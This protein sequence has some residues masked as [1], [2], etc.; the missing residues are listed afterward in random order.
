MSGATLTTT[1]DELGAA[2]VLMSPSLSEPNKNRQ[3]PNQRAQL[4]VADCRASRAP[5][6]PMCAHTDKYYSTTF[7]RTCGEPI[8]ARKERVTGATVC[9]DFFRYCR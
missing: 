8:G 5:V 4:E 7:P 6:E 3:K 2:S 9:I 1:G